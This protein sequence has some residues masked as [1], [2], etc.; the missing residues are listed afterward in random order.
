MARHMHELINIPLSPPRSAIHLFF[1]QLHKSRI[2][3]K[4]FIS[5][6]ASTF[7][8]KCAP[9]PSSHSFLLS[10]KAFSTQNHKFLIFSW[11]STIRNISSTPLLSQQLP[12]HACPL[13]PFPLP[14]LARDPARGTGAPSHHLGVQ[15]GYKLSHPQ[16]QIHPI[17][18]PWPR[19]QRPTPFACARCRQRSLRSLLAKC[20][21][22]G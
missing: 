22:P 19:C 13:L 3:K 9:C 10:R 6:E 18:N 17:A 2:H 4:Q 11:A 14:L 1:I 20:H 16:P 7:P 21:P 8:S 15:P 12:R 5:C